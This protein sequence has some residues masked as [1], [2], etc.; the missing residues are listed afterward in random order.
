MSDILKKNGFSSFG[1]IPDINLRNA[2]NHGTVSLK[3]IGGSECSILYTFTERHESCSR[4][5]SSG[6]LNHQILTTLGKLYAGML[7]M[8]VVFEANG[9]DSLFESI[10]SSYIRDMYFGLQTGGNA[11]RCMD[12]QEVVN[13]AQISYT[14]ETCEKSR[15]ALFKAAES[16]I[17]GLYSRM[18]NFN[19]YY[20]SFMN[21]RL[22]T[23][24]L[25][26][27]NND[28]KTFIAGGSKTGELISRIIRSG[29]VLWMDAS[30]ENINLNEA[31]YYRFPF[32]ED[33]E[34]HIYDVEDASLRDRKRLK[35]R[36]FIGQTV[37]RAE[38]VK[39]IETAVEWVAS[40]YNP[41]SATFG[42]KHGDMKADCVYLN[43]YRNELDEDKSLFENNRNFVCQVEYCPYSNFRLADINPLI[44]YLYQNSQWINK[45][46]R[47][48]WREKKYLTIENPN[49]VRHNDPCPCGSEKKI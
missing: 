39:I 31:E 18:P 47:L 16:I 24:F 21:P 13:S 43:I 46:I 40:L 27:K 20:I 19:Q 32:Y 5:L 28:V 1:S 33:E 12:V 29:D 14:F 7:G 30:D 34:M 25:R 35:A 4:T 38:I 49:K 23:N 11:Y 3:A 48:L 22:P 45:S 2:I 10:D 37:G 6:D 17:A 41:P 44:K 36:V 8:L 42:I 15:S 26:A 9:I